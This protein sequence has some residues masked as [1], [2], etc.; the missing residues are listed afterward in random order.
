M[1]VAVDDFESVL[2]HDLPLLLELYISSTNLSI[3]L[4]RRSSIRGSAQWSAR[5]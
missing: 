2:R 1:H 5:K 3:Q 4:D